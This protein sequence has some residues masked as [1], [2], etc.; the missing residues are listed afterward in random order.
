VYIRN[1]NIDLVTSHNV[2]T[3]EYCTR[4]FLY[5]YEWSFFLLKFG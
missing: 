5:Y 3:R 4:I 2:K 1:D